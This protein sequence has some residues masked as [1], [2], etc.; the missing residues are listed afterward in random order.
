MAAQAPWSEEIAIAIVNRHAGRP[1]ATLPI[2][3]ALQDEFG[4]VD[5][6][7]VPLI[8]DALNISRAE[9]HGIVSFYPEF[10]Q[11]PAGR[12]VI[13]ICRAEA[14]QANGCEQLVDAVRARSGVSPDGPSSDRLTVESV[15]C[16][17]NC[18][19]GPS[20]LVDGELVGRLDA[21]RLSAL[22]DG[23]PVEAAQVAAH[24]AAGEGPG[25]GPGE[26][27]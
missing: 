5:A 7:A 22:C 23:A 18:A 15:Y 17:G 8:A 6:A 14:C 16:L 10:R 3:H 2:L 27:Q 13:R 19:L 1:G 4:Y 9:V 21:D 25:E 20:A 26:G 12:R 24:V 11:A